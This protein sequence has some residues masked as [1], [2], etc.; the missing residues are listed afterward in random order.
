MGKGELAQ[1]EGAGL[2]PA[3]TTTVVEEMGRAPTRDAPT[4]TVEGKGGRGGGFVSKR[5]ANEWSGGICFFLWWKRR[6]V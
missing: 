5:W 3:P 6:V 4:T 1:R 2:K